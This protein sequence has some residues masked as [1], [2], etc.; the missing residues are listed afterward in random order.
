MS[1]EG[2]PKTVAPCWPSLETITAMSRDISGSQTFRKI[3]N[4][5]KEGEE[6]EEEEEEVGGT[7]QPENVR[8]RRGAGRRCARYACGSGG[9]GQFEVPSSLFRDID[10]QEEAMDVIITQRLHERNA[11]SG[12]AAWFSILACYGSAIACFATYII[13]RFDS[14]S[15]CIVGGGERRG[16]ESL[17]EPERLHVPSAPRDLQIKSRKAMKTA[18]CCSQRQQLP[19]PATNSTAG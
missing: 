4:F 17:P 19:D 6:E 2:K 13:I 11:S 12:E 3:L 5:K 15:L 16:F 8:G 14:I 7:P 18:S 1:F 9:G 10:V